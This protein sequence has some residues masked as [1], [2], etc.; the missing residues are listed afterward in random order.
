MLEK[1]SLGE[2]IFLF[3]HCEG[4]PKPRVKRGGKRRGPA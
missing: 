4:Q 3:S 1:M 2:E